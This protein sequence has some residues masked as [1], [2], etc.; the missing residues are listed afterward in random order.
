MKFLLQN[1]ALFHGAIFDSL[2]FSSTFVRFSYDQVYEMSM[3]GY[4][5][6][7]WLPFVSQATFSKRNLYSLILFVIFYSSAII[8]RYLQSSIL[9]LIDY[10][11]I[12]NLTMR[13]TMPARHLNIKDVHS[14][15]ALQ[16]TPPNHLSLFLY[17][18]QRS[19]IS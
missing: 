19:L 8:L 13:S 6:S 4:K 5:D 9:H 1:L 10:P 7:L 18:Y 14:N 16:S 17:I 12:L 3:I 11:A 15:P 2:R